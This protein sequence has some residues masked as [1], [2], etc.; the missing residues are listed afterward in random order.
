LD[1]RSDEQG[2]RRQAGMKLA[3]PMG[4]Q[5]T[6]PMT[7]QAA[8]SNVHLPTER[9]STAVVFLRIRLVTVMAIHGPEDVRFWTQNGAEE[10]MQYLRSR[11]PP[12]S[13]G[14]FT[15]CQQF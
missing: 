6:R 10:L 15:C 5:I 14:E 1:G 7:A 4:A 3:V 8:P 12:K 2:K 13:L 11:R 9:S